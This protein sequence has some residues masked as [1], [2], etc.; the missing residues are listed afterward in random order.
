MKIAVW[1]GM[2][3]LTLGGPAAAET[4]QAYSRSQNNAFMADADSIA[5]EGGITSIR[6]ATVPRA[7]E[8]GDLSHSIE[9]YQFRCGASQWRTAGVVE[10]GPDGSEAGQYPEED[11]AWEP[12]RPNTMPNYLKEIACDG[13][14]A[15]PPHWP[16]I[17]AFIEAGRP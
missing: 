10:Y 2:V 6:V 7:G 11:A 8:S 3:A 15:V 12:V 9:T 5:A 1:M 13:A 4:W 14:R 16:S 17:Q